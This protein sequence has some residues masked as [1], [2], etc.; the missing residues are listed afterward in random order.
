MQEQN[1]LNVP[2][3]ISTMNQLRKA[4]HQ[5]NDFAAMVAYGFDKKIT[6]NECV[7]GMMKIYQKFSK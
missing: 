4:H 7:A 6:E 2:F 5:K 1:I 3:P